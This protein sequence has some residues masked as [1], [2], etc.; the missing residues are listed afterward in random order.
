MLIQ[1]FW[2]K[3]WVVL[4]NGLSYW[5]IDIFNNMYSGFEALVERIY[6]KYLLF[7][8]WF[9]FSLFLWREI[10]LNDPFF[11]LCAWALFKKSWPGF[12]IT[13]TFDVWYFLLKAVSF[14][15]SILG[16]D[17]SGIG[18]SV[19]D[20]RERVKVNFFHVLDQQPFFCYSTTYLFTY[21]G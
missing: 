6:C 4:L 1:V 14:F 12:K 13:K 2:K 17:T 21:F 3:N 11:F 8:L 9:T 18:F 20:V 10:P 15:V 7:F 5:I 16:C 19:H